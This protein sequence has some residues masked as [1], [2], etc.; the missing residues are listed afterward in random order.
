MN[1]PLLHDWTIT[2]QAADESH[3]HFAEAICDLIADAAQKRGTGIARR[4]PDYIKTKM[5]ESKA[6]IALARQSDEAAVLAG[7]CYIETWSEKRYVANSGLIVGEEFRKSGLARR[8]KQFAFEHSRR[9]F[10]N[11]RIFGI[12]TS[13]AVMKINS[14]LGYLPVHYSELTEDEEF[15]RG[16]NT[17][18]NVDVLQRTKRSMCLCTAMLYRPTP[19]A[20]DKAAEEL[21]Q[22]EQH[23]ENAETS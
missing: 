13:A 2:V 6:I 11:A 10:P 23:P 15:W 19:P 12:T 22:N 1:Q 8:I 18:P 14:E 16:C 9:M 5:G 20:A 7:F 3:T 21:K 17:C 4:S